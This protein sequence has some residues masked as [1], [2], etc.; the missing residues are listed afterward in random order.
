MYIIKSCCG[1]YEVRK[2]IFISNSY[3]S[4][5]LN[6]ITIVGTNGLTSIRDDQITTR[7]P[8]D[9]FNEKGSFVQ[10]PIISEQ[11]YNLEDEYIAS[12]NIPAVAFFPKIQKELNMA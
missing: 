9:T 8:R 7:S 3:A 6:E 5:Y 11:E 10:P 4:P 2:T 1:K 12:L